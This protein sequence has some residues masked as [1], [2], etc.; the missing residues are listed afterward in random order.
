M[1]H[2]KKF[3]LLIIILVIIFLIFVFL[4]GIYCLS[5]LHGKRELESSLEDLHIRFPNSMLLVNEKFGNDLEIVD[6]QRWDINIICKFS[7]EFENKYNVSNKKTEDFLQDIA[8]EWFE[9][10]HDELVAELESDYT[11]FKFPVSISFKFDSGNQYELLTF[12]YEDFD[13]CNVIRHEKW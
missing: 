5:I 7:A 9:C 1:V 12:S 13:K 10:F 11:D 2:I 3:K 8:D 6:V 4:Y